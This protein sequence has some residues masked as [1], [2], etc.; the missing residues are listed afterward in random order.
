MSLNT[1]VNRYMFWEMLPPF[2]ISLLFMIFVFLMATIL[3]ITKLIVNYRV[4][5]WKV[6]LFVVYAIPYRL[7]FVIPMAIMMAILLTFLRMSSDNEIM[8][9]KASGMSIYRLLPPAFLF[10][11]TGALLT[12]FMTIFGSPW[13]KTA[14]RSL[15]YEV[16]QVHLDAGLKERKFNDTFENVML[17]V[18]KIDLKRKVLIDVFIEDQRDAR[19]VSTVVAPR[20]RLLQEE[21]PSVYHLQLY[22]GI[23]NQVS[24]K[25]KTSHAVHFDIYDMRLDLKKAFSGARRRIKDEEE[26]SIPELMRHIDSAPQKDTAYYVALMEFH[27]K[28]SLPVACIVLGLLA[29]PLGIQSHG[30]TRS[31]GIALGMFFFMLYYFLLSAAWVFGEVGLYPPLIG[32]WMPNL[33]MGGIGLGLIIWTAKERAL[34]IAAGLH[35]L[36]QITAKLHI[37][38]R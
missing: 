31:F 12:A 3:K 26:M 6:I 32:M 25:E 30:S 23:L 28:F 33:L 19:G 36:K 35:F 20:G 7:E 9:L 17:Y 34:P 16:A 4:S 10:C 29:V 21:D 2:F 18:S 11:L 38:F 8:A 5:L 24:L 15:T 37:P 1:I 22:N 27:K 13:G 14:F